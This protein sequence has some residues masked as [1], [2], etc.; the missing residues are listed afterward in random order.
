MQTIEI[1]TGIN[2]CLQTVYHGFLS[3]TDD[4]GELTADVH[5]TTADENGKARAEAETD[6]GKRNSLYSRGNSQLT[7]RSQ[8]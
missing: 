4:A 1:Y 7:A 5:E 3:D 2:A 8:A 6:D